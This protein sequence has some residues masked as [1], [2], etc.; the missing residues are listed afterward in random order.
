MNRSLRIPLLALGAAVSLTALAGC[1]D[2]LSDYGGLCSVYAATPDCV[3]PYACFCRPGSNCVCTKRC[4]Q[5]TDCPK[6]SV[7]V[8]GTN[9]ATNTQ[10]LFCFVS[11]DGGR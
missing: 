7:C 1:S 9:P 6:G 2:S 11:H 10:D 8:P 5:D 3:A 4:Q